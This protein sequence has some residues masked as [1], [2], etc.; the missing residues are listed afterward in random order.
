MNMKNISI[1]LL[2]I[3]TITSGLYISCSKSFL[4]EE[5]KSNYAPSTIYKDTAGFEA[6]VIGLQELLRE[7]YGVGEPQGLIAIWQVGTDVAISP[8]S[9]TAEGS[10]VPYANYSQLISTDNAALKYWKWGYEV[11]NSANL[12]LDALKDSASLSSI[13]AK[14]RNLFNAE[15][16]FAR[17]YAY[18]F[19]S[20][21]WG[22]V[23]LIDQPVKTPKFDFT[24]AEVG[25]IVDFIIKDLEF[26]VTYLPDVAQVKTDERFNIAMARQLLAEVYIRAG[27]YKKDASFY[28]LAE[29]QCQAIIGSGLFTL[30]TQ[31]YGI[32]AAQ[33]GDPFSDMFLYGNQRRRQGNKEAIWVIEEDFTL[34]QS[35]GGGASNISNNGANDQHR[36]VWVP[37]YWDKGL[38]FCDSLGGR[39]LARIS[40]STWVCYNL[41]ETQDMRNSQFNIRR[42]YWGNNPANANY[43]QLI[44]PA[45]NADGSIV[46]SDTLYRICP[47]TTKW[48]SYIASNPDALQ[49]TCIKDM[50]M[51]RLGETYLLQAEAQFKNGKPDDAATSINVLRTRA[52]ATPITSASVNLD[53]ILD[54]RAREL[55]AEE[56]RRQTL[57]R[58]GK[59]YDRVT[60][61]NTFNSGATIRPENNLMPIPQTEI[62]LNKGA[63]LQQNPGY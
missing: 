36:R 38:T 52:N 44:V 11:I 54:E 12:I 31:R 5:L 28:G 18:N 30:T 57:A 14:N 42:K 6:A 51:M 53:F 29:Q 60:K 27:D 55:L 33:A 9:T 37:R 41:Y 35:N 61:L 3:L 45:K 50:I 63:V 23:P 8:S 2:L 58:T 25:T 62:D 39:G 21:N 4:D 47:S 19:L 15:A 48:N 34:S 24:R 59:L 13:P 22:G 16:K 32:K 49:Y 20:I 26:A 43:K 40:L 7:Q 56:N 46:A 17:A 1:K 10:Q